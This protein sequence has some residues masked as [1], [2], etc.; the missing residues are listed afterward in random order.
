MDDRERARPG[1]LRGL[2]RR[3]IDLGQSLAMLRRSQVCLIVGVGIVFR[4][5]QYLADRPFWMDEHSLAANVVPGRYGGLFGPLHNNQLAPPGF[6]AVARLACR[7]L[8]SSRMALRVVPLL[9]GIASLFLFLVLCRRSLQP[10][11]LL[12]AVALFAVTDDLIAYCAELKQYETDVAAALI[13]TL[14]GLAMASRPIPISRWLGFAAAGALVVWFSHPS[15]F[16]LAGVGTT[17][18]VAAIGRRAWPDAAAFGVVC[19]AWLASFAVVHAVAMEQLHHGREM[20]AFWG[21]AFP[22]WPPATLHHAAWP[23]LRLLYYFVN[24]LSFETPLNP[25]LSALLGLGFF[26]VGVVSIWKRDRILF[27]MLMLPIAFTLGAAFLRLYPFHGRLIL[28]L[29]PSYLLPIAEGAARIGERFNRRAVWALILAALFLYPV[30]RD[31]NHLLTPRVRGDFSPYGD[32]R[33]FRL[34][35]PQ[36]FPF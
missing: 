23:A 4:V 21:F 20:W 10:V 27:G 18:I 9:S 3:Q 14:L 5:A 33:Y 30:L 19:L 32:R 1:V 31:L 17:L 7:A 13:C 12:I 6:L 8:G 28:F 29:A 26:A 16:V 15:A 2:A 34:Y 36:R 11:P 35:D 25:G 24:P 22:P